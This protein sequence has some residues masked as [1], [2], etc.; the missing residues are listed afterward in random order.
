GLLAF[1]GRVGGTVGDGG[2]AF[3]GY[4]RAK[5]KYQLSLA[6]SLYYQNLDNNA[7]VLF[8][9][10]DEVEEQEFREAILAYFLLWQRAGNEGWTQQR[11]DGEAENLLAT[12]LG[13]DVDFEVDDAL[14]KLVRLKL[15]AT[16]PG[17]RYTAIPIQEALRRLDE[18][19]DGYFEYHTPKRE[20][21]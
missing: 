16:Q 11:L 12:Q 5:D 1:V 7:G 21:A 13:R 14:A 17:G 6:R 19:W 3:F 9:L 15:V 10:L 18:A 2:K 8:R 4:L 20:A